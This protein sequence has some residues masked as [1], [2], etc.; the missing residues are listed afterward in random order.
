MKVAIFTSGYLRT[1]FYVFRQNIELISKKLGNCEIDVYYSFWDKNHRS[2]I[3][4]DPWCYK[5]EDTN[6]DEVNQEKI[7]SY[8]LSFGVNKVRGEIEPFSVSEQIMSNSVFS[9]EK[10]KLSSQY[11]KIHRVAKK[12][13][14]DEYDL[15]L[16]L[17]PD[18][19]I[20]DF[21]SVDYIKNIN[22][23]NSIVVNQ[24]YWY[25]AV[26]DK[27]DCNEYIWLSTKNNFIDSNSQYKNLNQLV[28]QS[29]DL[30]G[31]AITA[32]HFNNLFSDKKISSINVFN[33][34]YRVF[35]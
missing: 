29:F 25:N 32:Q 7:E 16:T 35:R 2:N 10:S 13:F 24:Y 23:Q 28:K 12:Y 22:L 26:Y 6:L 14:T 20:N 9:K 15:Y 30:H 33:F 17:R 27:R 21:I 4:N 11:Y 8:L 3:I 18:V 34:D 1:F 31:E 19:V 5:V